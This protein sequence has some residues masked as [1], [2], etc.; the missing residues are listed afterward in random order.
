MVG[1][2]RGPGR[3]DRGATGG[4]GAGRLRS[5]RQRRGAPGSQAPRALRESCQSPA[6]AAGRRGAPRAEGAVDRQRVVRQ[7]GRGD[8]RRG[9]LT[10]ERVGATPASPAG[11]GGTRS[12]PGRRRRRPYGTETDVQKSPGPLAGGSG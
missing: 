11:S 12:E 5:G 8:I 3:R 10:S 2:P 9:I 6:G 1:V 7:V 4:G